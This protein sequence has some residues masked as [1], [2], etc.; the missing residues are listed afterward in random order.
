[1]SLVKDLD[2]EAMPTSI[3]LNDDDFPVLWITNPAFS[4]EFSFKTFTVSAETI[5]RESHKL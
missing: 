4:I 3:F 1:M 2:L 5:G